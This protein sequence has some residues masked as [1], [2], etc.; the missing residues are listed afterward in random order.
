MFVQSG[1]R[2]AGDASNQPASQPDRQATQ[3]E[4]AIVGAIPVIQWSAFEADVPD[5]LECL[6]AL[7]TAA[8]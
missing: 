7:G 4:G 2:L 1:D 8:S 3:E 6:S 5:I